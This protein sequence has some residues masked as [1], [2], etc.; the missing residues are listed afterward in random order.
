MHPKLVRYASRQLDVDTASEVAVDVM[1]A[2]WSKNPSQP[3]TEVADRQL[4]RLCYRICDGAIRNAL[5]AQRRHNTLVMAVA[6]KTGPTE[7]VPDVADLVTRDTS[8]DILTEVSKTD[9]Q[10][11]ALIAD[12]YRVSEIAVV[13][14]T[15]P[16]AVSMRLRRAKAN[17]QRA[18]M[19][20][21]TIEGRDR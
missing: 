3:K 2:F 12:G 5:R 14:G 4:Q 10:V 16:A 21:G 7:P 1:R 11:L 6:S 9:R 17:V 20:R 18:L 19:A 15:S 13:L 8:T